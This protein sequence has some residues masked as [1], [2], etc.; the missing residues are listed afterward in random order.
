MR[1]LAYKTHQRHLGLRVDRKGHLYMDK[2][3]RGERSGLG[4][5]LPAIR[6]IGNN[7]LAS[8]GT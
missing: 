5:W 1:I 7:V 3:Q 2:W 6:L 4:L 8:F